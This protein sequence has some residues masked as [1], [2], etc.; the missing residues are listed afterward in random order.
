MS[1]TALRLRYTHV[2]AFASGLHLN[3]YGMGKR[4]TGEERGMKPG[5]RIR[6][7]VQRLNLLTFS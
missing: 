4:L 1:R 7:R 3:E 5:G 6:H 2:S